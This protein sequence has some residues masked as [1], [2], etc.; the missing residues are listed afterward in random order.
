MISSEE[1]RSLVACLSTALS[2]LES[3]VLALYLDGHSYEQIGERLGCDTQDGRQRAA[4]RQAQGR[5]APELA[6]RH[7]VAR[8]HLADHRHDRRRP[9]DHGPARPR[10]LGTRRR[11][12]RPTARS[13]RS[14]ARQ[15]GARPRP[16]RGQGLGA[17]G[18]RGGRP[19]RVR[20]APP[21][22]SVR[23]LH[24]VQVVDRPGTDEDQAVFR[25]V[26]DH[27]ERDVVLGRRAATG[28]R[29][30]ADRRDLH[31]PPGD[32]I[33]NNPAF[34]VL[35][36]RGRPRGPRRPRRLPR[37]LR[38]PRLDRLL[39]RRRLRLPS[40]PLDLPRG[41][42]RRGRCRDPRA[43]AARRASPSP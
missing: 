35:I 2:E 28:T 43:P 42:R 18:A 22:R 36:Y 1:L 16:R 11:A 3:R 23:E 30:R 40:L 33:P 10:R 14:R 20:A 19:R 24:L 26:N 31:A 38:L 34:P 29:S 9:G 8:E 5:R 12:A 41:P 37:P 4:A 7:P 27:G 15:P 25:V 21:G 39:G 32:A 13:T 17:L 6:Q